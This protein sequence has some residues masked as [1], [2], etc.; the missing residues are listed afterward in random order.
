MPNPR[1][2]HLSGAPHIHFP[3]Y[4]K[5][6]SIQILSLDPPK[7]FPK[8]VDESYDYGDEEEDE[9]IAW[10][11]PRY[12]SAVWDTVGRAASRDLASFKSL[13]HKLWKPF[14][15]PILDGQFG[16]RDFSKLLVA[17]KGIFQNEDL[18]SGSNL[19]AQQIAQPKQQLKRPSKFLPA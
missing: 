5:D 16:T 17:R 15:Q 3:P 11:W 8:P 12:C 6:E 4:N 7:I 14:V 1:L 18:L 2:L 9:D 10:L 19:T 13:C